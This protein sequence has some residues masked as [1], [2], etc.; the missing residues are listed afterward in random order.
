V[1]KNAPAPPG[2]QTDEKATTAMRRTNTQTGAKFT[3]R[4]Q[5]Y[6]QVGSF[7]LDME[8]GHTIRILELETDCPECGATFDLTATLRQIERRILNR[9]CER[10]RKT[11]RGPVDVRKIEQRKARKEAR[12]RVRRR[13]TSALPIPGKPQTAAVT[14]GAVSI[15]PE[16]TDPGARCALT[17]DARKGTSG[18]CAVDRRRRPGSLHASPWH[19]LDVTNTDRAN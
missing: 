8:C 18:H 11:H 16:R 1:R 3:V 10:C 5:P 7:P 4:G 15:A 13:Q 9:R 17:S 12:E 6:I 19:G 14:T 2:Q